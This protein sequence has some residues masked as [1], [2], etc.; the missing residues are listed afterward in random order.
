MA[1]DNH[2]TFKCAVAK[3]QTLADGAL[4]VWFDLPEDATF[5][6]AQLMACQ[7]HGVYLEAE[8]VPQADEQDGDYWDQQ[9]ND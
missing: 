5:A 6:A 4:R 7:R 1:D 3:V 2:I 9:V 8:L